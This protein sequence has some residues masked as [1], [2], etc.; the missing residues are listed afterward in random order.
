MDFLS[1]CPTRQ[2]FGISK[3]ERNDLYEIEWIVS[4]SSYP[5]LIINRFKCTQIIEYQF[6][7]IDKIRCACKFS[8]SYTLLYS[9]V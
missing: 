9:A 5:P 3:H 4:K 7:L 6:V 8:I 1:I 2:V